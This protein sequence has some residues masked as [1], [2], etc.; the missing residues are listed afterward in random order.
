[1]L[2]GKALFK[3]TNLLNNVLVLYKNSAYS[4]Y[5]TQKNAWRASSGT[6]ALKEE[7]HRFQEAH[8]EH[9]KALKMVEGILRHYGIRYAKHARG[10]NISYDRYQLIITVGGDGTFLEAAR[11]VQSQPM[12]GVNSAPRFSAG[13]LCVA[14]V[15]NLE[16]IIQKIVQRSYR[17]VFW[18]RLHLKFAGQRQPIDCL[19]DIL[20]CHQNPAAVSRYHLRIRG[21]H[22][23][24][25][26]SGLWIAT[27]VG[28]SG[29]IRSAGGKILKTTA[30]KL[31]Y[32]P[33]ELYG[34]FQPRYRLRGDVLPE[35]S[36][37]TITSLMPNGMIFVDG[38]HLPL[39]FS[40]NAMLKV[41][42]SSRPL[43]VIQ[44]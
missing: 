29:A 11:N 32:L 1:M 6:T 35:R 22:E 12:L 14:T 38:T 21:I 13:K 36:V 16:E 5:F 9:F 10:Q 41:S 40:F 18:Q 3:P 25:R 31:Q 42:L 7:L 30:K 39:K 23:E 28:S 44:S 24:Q 8:K 4:L 43:Q 33:R 19:N 20:I 15:L 17:S 27:A 37:I 26:S 34:G 2:T